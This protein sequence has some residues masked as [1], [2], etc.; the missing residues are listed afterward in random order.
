MARLVGASDVAGG[1]LM[2]YA[3]FA[4]WLCLAIYYCPDDD[5]IYA[6]TVLFD[7]I[8]EIGLYVETGLVGGPAGR[9]YPVSL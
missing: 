1:Q 8:V 6:F 9:R 5:C 2:E 4:D 3:R 7:Q